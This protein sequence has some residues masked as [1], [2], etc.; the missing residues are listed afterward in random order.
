M[1][2]KLKRAALRALQRALLPLARIALRAGVPFADFNEVAKQAFVRGARD[3]YGIRGR[4]TNLSRV[5]VLT[6]LSRKECGRLK[7]DMEDETLV[8]AAPSLNPATK[9][10]AVWNQD[11]K[12]SD[13]GVP[14]VLP[15]RGSAPSLQS[16]IAEH[17]GDIPEGAVIAELERVGALEDREDGVRLLQRSFLP[18][19]LNEEKLR[20]LANQF[21]DLGETVVFNLGDVE[22][23]RM[24]R[25]VVN[26]YI[27]REQVAEFQA[28]ATSLTQSLLEDLDDWLSAHEQIENLSSKAEAKVR[29]GLGV[30]FFEQPWP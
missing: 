22:K 12:Y 19:G 24:Q 4:P 2:E 3:D 25:Y 21:A 10:M 5:A 27:P 26:D 13:N 8:G 7:R 30:Y 28:L 29:T 6:G 20:I 9:V 18:A 14:R 17:I 1:E 15:R 23:A 11:P 16:L